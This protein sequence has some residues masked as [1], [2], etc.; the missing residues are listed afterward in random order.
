[1]GLNTYDQAQQYCI[2]QLNAIREKELAAGKSR[3]EIDQILKQAELQLINQFNAV[4]QQTLTAQNGQLSQQQNDSQSEVQE[5][6]GQLEEELREDGEDGEDDSDV[7][8][9][10]DKNNGANPF[11]NPYQLNG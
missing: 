6:N 2:N 9:E 5:L 1:M 4:Q 3:V 7:F 8:N 11:E 10:I